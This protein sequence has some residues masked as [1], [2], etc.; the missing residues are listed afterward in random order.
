MHRGKP[1]V[2][3]MV[4]CPSCGFVAL[5]FHEH[6]EFIER[7]SVLVESTNAIVCTLCAREV[8]IA[9]G[10]IEARTKDAVRAQGT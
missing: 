8:R 6:V 5:H 2:G 10:R 4:A 3:Y 9:D 1:L 7:D